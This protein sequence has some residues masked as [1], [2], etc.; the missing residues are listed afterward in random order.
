MILLVSIV[1]FLL[2]WGICLF[3]VLVEGWLLLV[4]SLVVDSML[5]IV[6]IILCVVFVYIFFVIIVCLVNYKILN[7]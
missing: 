6:V 2:V 7:M 1:L 5:V 4:N 3:K